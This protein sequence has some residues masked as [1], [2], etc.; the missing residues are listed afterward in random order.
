MCIL[1]GRHSGQG[2]RL[3]GPPCDLFLA[4]GDLSRYASVDKIERDPSCHRALSLATPCSAF[5]GCT[6]L[7]PHGSAAHP[8]LLSVETTKSAMDGSLADTVID[9]IS[10]LS[11]SDAD[12]L[13]FVAPQV[14]DR[15]PLVDL[16]T[17]EPVRSHGMAMSLDT[18]WSNHCLLYTSDAADE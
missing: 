13:A 4:Q 6:S 10:D 9:S 1:D 7:H 17:H 18:A 14:E 3:T 8:S 5:G 12:I 11:Q 15:A 16:G 2:H